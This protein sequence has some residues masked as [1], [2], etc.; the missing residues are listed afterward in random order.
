[1]K[2]DR[3]RLLQATGVSLALPWL[4]V[5]A[6][7]GG[8]IGPRRR[9]VCICAPLGFYPPNFFPENA[10]TDYQPSPY[11]ELLSDFRNDFTV[12]SGLAHTGGSPGFAHQA[13]AS[14]L[15]GAPGAGR[16]GF[17]NTISLDQYAAQHIGSHT[18]F[19]SLILS[20]E[21]LG[22]SWTSTGAQIPADNSPSRVFERMF[23]DGSKSEI[24]AQ[25]MRLEKGRSILDGVGEQAATLRSELGTDD[26]GK[27]DE[28]LT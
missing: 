1:M 17:R 21:G 9:M 24:S 25:L 4:N 23:L 20:G 11:L 14:F 26:I 5:F 22:L 10:G 12:I 28:Y 6:K 19:P 16:P 8:S 13:T 18:R 27:L 3:R 15:T 7:D 2:I